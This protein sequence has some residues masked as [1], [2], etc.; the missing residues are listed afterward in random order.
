MMGLSLLSAL[1]FDKQKQRKLMFE[2]SCVH[3][4]LQILFVP[5]CQW[6][7]CHLQIQKLMTDQHESSSVLCHPN[8]RDSSELSCRQSKSMSSP[9]SSPQAYFNRGSPLALGDLKGPA[10]TQPQFS[11][12]IQLHSHHL[13]INHNRQIILLKLQKSPKCNMFLESKNIYDSAF[14]SISRVLTWEWV[15]GLSSNTRTAVE[16]FYVQTK[17]LLLSNQF[18]NAPTDD[19]Y[20]ISCYLGC[21]VSFFFFHSSAITSFSIVCGLYAS[22][23]HAKQIK[24]NGFISINLPNAP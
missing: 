22:K 8:G 16:F 23:F 24:I 7:N 19:S 4:G 3:H 20:T 2:P 1:S 21:L 11:R 12:K 15:F 6:Q 10:S 13:S 17:G 18:C 9:P 14:F 5:N